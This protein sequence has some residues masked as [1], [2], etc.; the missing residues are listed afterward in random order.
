MS[1]TNRG[2]PT[3]RALIRAVVGA[4]AAATLPAVAP[5]TVTAGPTGLVAAYGFEEGSGTTRGGCVGERQHGHARER[6]LDNAGKYGEALVVQRDERAGDG[7]GLG[8][9]ASLD[10]G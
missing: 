8:L 4:A 6:D 5:T 2:R 10:A 7:P 9:A 1:W 3:W